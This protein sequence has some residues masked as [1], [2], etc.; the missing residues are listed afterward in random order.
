MTTNCNDTCDAVDELLLSW[1]CR[2]QTDARGSTPSGFFFRSMSWYPL[3]LIQKKTVSFIWVVFFCFFSNTGKTKQKQTKKNAT[4]LFERV[5]PPPITSHWRF[6]SLY[7]SQCLMFVCPAKTASLNSDWR[8]SRLSKGCGL[9]LSPFLFCSRTDQCLLQYQLAFC[10]TEMCIPNT[11]KAVS[12]YADYFQ[13]H[14]SFILLN[15][16]TVRC[17]Y[18]GPLWWRDP[19]L[20]TVGKMILFLFFL[21]MLL[22]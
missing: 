16:V 3:T 4:K 17:T 13:I 21:D 2:E 15:L 11:T 14:F 1:L 22:P 10:C 20:L 19:V 8:P 12:L 9:T 7:V 6:V 18:W 5:Q